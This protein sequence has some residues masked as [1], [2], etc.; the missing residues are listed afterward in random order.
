MDLLM[1]NGQSRVHCQTIY[2]SFCDF[3]ATMGFFSGKK[4]TK[5]DV[6]IPHPN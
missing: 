3:W 5:R 2:I 6:K 1:T 4:R